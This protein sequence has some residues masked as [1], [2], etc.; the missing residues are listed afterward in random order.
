MILQEMKELTSHQ[1]KA[2]D[3]RKHISLTANAGSGKTFVLSHR[4]IDIAL[5]EKGSLSKIAAITFT[6]K[7]AAELYSKIAG[8]VELRYNES[9]DEEEKKVLSKIRRGLVS[10]NIA[11]IHSFCIDI[12]RQFPVQAGLDANFQPVD[13]ITSGELIE[14]SVEETI[15]ESLSGGQESDTAK[16]LIRLFGSKFILSSQLNYLIKDRKKIFSISEEI[17]DQPEEKIAAKFYTDFCLTAGK[18][19]QIDQ[20]EFVKALTVI[21]EAVLSVQ[22]SNRAALTI[23]NLLI[24]FISDVSLER[25]LELLHSIKENAFRKGGT[26]RKDGYLKNET[27][28][29]L[30][31]KI[32]ISEKYI[33]ELSVLKIPANHKEIET[34]LAKLGKAILGLFNKAVEKYESK[35]RSNGYLD[36]EDILIHTRNLLK[37]RRIKTELSFRFKY[38]MID[39]Y[40]DTNEIQYKIFLPILDDLR[41][42]NLFV[43][44][45]EK[46]SIYMFRDAEPEIFRITKRDIS[47]TSGEKS[48]LS[49]PD[50]F[51]MAPGDACLSIN[52]SGICFQSRMRYSMKCSILI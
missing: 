24:E 41:T 18:L 43:V 4:Y 27:R 26:I 13:E 29:K 10:A 17:Y 14:L 22:N 46:Q 42:G 5:S 9:K 40:Q 21:N 12:L 52:Y 36:Y 19:I 6:D 50:S 38:I 51:R 34:E 48:L 39:E 28:E 47:S 37:D 31:P 1:Q 32:L 20:N 11:T 8:Q 44:G 25:K 16:Y 7:A 45:D 33:N 2:L 15:K 3:F 30:Y 35:K 49:L 23:K